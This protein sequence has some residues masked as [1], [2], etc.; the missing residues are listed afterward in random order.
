MSDLIL[1]EGKEMKFIKKKELMNRKFAF[2]IK[3]VL[4][5]FLNSN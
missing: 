3:E 1:S 5:S 2:N 4:S